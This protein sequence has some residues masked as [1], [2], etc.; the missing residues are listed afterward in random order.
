MKPYERVH[1]LIRVTSTLVDGRRLIDVN[2]QIRA[3]NRCC[4][5]L[6]HF[7]QRLRS[8]CTQANEYTAADVKLSQADKIQ[9]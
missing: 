1:T 9:R 8:Q 6:L 4:I 5:Y 2:L 3:D 7:V